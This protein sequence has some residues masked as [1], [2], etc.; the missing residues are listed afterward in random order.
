MAQEGDRARRAL[1][2]ARTD[3]PPGRW[4]ARGEAEEDNHLSER[5]AAERDGVEPLK[6]VVHGPSEFVMKYFAAISDPLRF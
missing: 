2:E 1:C 3:S 6:D 4:C 5:R